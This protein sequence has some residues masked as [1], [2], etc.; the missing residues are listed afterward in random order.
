M[1]L[2]PI[3]LRPDE[4]VSAIASPQSVRRESLDWRVRVSGIGRYLPKRRVASA[5]IEARA[6]LPL[7]WALA[8]SGVAFRHWVDRDERASWMGAAAAR[9]ACAKA[10]LQPGD[11]DLILNAS[12]TA[13]RAIPDGGPLLQDELGLGASGIPSFSVHA[14]C[15]SFLAALEIAAERI[16]HRRINRAL[17]ISSDI[18]S[19]GLNFNSPEIC[20][21]FGDGAAAVVLERAPYDST[22]A[23]HRMAWLTTG[24][25]ADLTTVRGCGSYRHPHSPDTVHE[26]ALFQMHGPRTLKRALRLAPRLL[27]M[28]GLD[29]STRE[30]VRWVA[31][32]QASRVALEHVARLGFDN[33][34][35]INTLQN[36]GNCIA[37]S[38]PLTLEQGVRA[39]Q[40]AR[41]DLGLLIGT[42]A[43]LSAAAMLMTY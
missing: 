41:G 32:H 38:I 11:M 23:I 43:G 30:R 19:V 27:G 34:V 1:T 28:L 16:H 31:S 14:T 17:V 12:G 40:I 8:H 22:S 25:D 10:G 7:G 21:L 2:D 39:G 26:D 5:E 36:I 13:E 20:T 37:A 33:A 4:S 9:D 6:R 3:P 42:G 24:E 35:V 29:A 18:A 15:L